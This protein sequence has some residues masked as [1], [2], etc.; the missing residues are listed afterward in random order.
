[1]LIA[2][3]GQ[4]LLVKKLFSSS[5]NLL[6]KNRKFAEI[7]T[8]LTKSEREQFLHS[9]KRTET[10]SESTALRLMSYLK[11][12]RVDRWNPQEAWQVLFPKKPFHEKSLNSYLTSLTGKLELFLAG[13]YMQP[14]SFQQ[15][16]LFLEFC[17]QRNL[18][19]AFRQKTNQIQ[20]R[21][22]D[23]PIDGCDFFQGQIDFHRIQAAFYTMRNKEKVILETI[24]Y[25][26]AI[27]KLWVAEHVISTLALQQYGGRQG[28]LEPISDRLD[29]LKE[30]SPFLSL[31]WMIKES[32]LGH[33]LISDTWKY[34]IT[35]AENIDR[36]DLARVYKLFLN[37][38]QSR[39]V[40]GH[41]IPVDFTT[42]LHEW[43]IKNRIFFSNNKFSQAV[44]QQQIAILAHYKDAQE[45]EA[46]YDQLLSFLPEENLETTQQFC[47][48]LI[49]YTKEDFSSMRKAWTRMS[50][51]SVYQTLQSNILACFA[52]YQ[53]EQILPD[54]PVLK[55]AILASIQ[56]IKKQISPKKIARADFREALL[57][58]LDVF[59]LF[60]AESP[61]WQNIQTI[62]SQTHPLN[63]REWLI[64]E[65]IRREKAEG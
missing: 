46:T 31:L 25:R 16:L 21:Y 17:Q 65:A 62:I 29:L 28:D 15:E 58:R 48:G 12:K 44:F 38:V 5:I 39:M 8:V 11:Q 52:S 47:L 36:F 40:L 7:W 53:E 13:Q 59:R 27:E 2:F 49:A 64:K 6:L 33:F 63:G 54:W 30:Q 61:D 23:D 10:T 9:L 18:P 56:K 14:S 50:K 51:P 20:K 43:A 60:L 35:H 55:D 42:K 37:D 41:N 57:N 22:L 34:F 26:K 3:F 1:M 45:A 19:K 4:L 32:R 24:E